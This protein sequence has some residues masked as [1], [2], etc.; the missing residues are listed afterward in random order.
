MINCNKRKIKSNSNFDLL[1]FEDNQKNNLYSK[2]KEEIGK[3]NISIKKLLERKE[4][5]LN[6]LNYSEV[7]KIDHRNY[8]QYYIYLL[9]YNH[10]ILFSFA[11]YNDYNIQIIKK[12]LF[13]FSFSLDFT[14]N[15]LFFTDETIHKIYQDKGKFNFIYQIPQTIYSI[16]IGKFIDSLIKTLALS[17]D[18]IIE[19]KQEKIKNL[20]KNIKKYYEKLI[21]NLLYFL[22]LYS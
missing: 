2:K 17:Q 21:R 8:C 18:N 6:S 20:E 10:P 5:E 12:F 7:L 11:C 3:N 15:A 19:L 16:L 14:I 4:F 13:F 1:N 22:L 9:K